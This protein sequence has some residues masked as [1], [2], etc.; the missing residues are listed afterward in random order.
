MEHKVKLKDGTEVVIRELTLDDLE[1]SV[2]FFRELPR[3]DRVYLRVGTK[4]KKDENRKCFSACGRRWRSDC[5]GRR[6][7]T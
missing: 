7:G 5:G 2:G 1:K 3:E 6:P 4:N